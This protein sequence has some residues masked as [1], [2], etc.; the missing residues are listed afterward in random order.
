[1]KV[2]SIQSAVA[3]GHVGNAGHPDVQAAIEDVDREI[4]SGFVS[5]FY[6]DAAMVPPQPGE[7]TI[8]PG[9]SALDGDTFAIEPMSPREAL[10][11]VLRVVREDREMRQDWMMR[12]FRQFDAPVCVIVT[13]DRTD[14]RGVRTVTVVPST[15]SSP[16]VKGVT[17]KIPS[18]SSVRPEPWQSKSSVFRVSAIGAMA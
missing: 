11:E 17:P 15:R 6:G 18:R 12:G 13:Y 2:L 14:W 5:Q 10:M 9:P 4:I 8:T 7:L 16:R 3:Y 1:M